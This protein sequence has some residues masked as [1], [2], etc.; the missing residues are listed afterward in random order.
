[1]PDEKPEL[2]TT[3]EQ[4]HRVGAYDLARRWVDDPAHSLAHR[5]R[6]DPAVQ[7]DELATMA[8]LADW[9]TRWLPTAIHRALLAGATVAQVAKAINMRPQQVTWTWECWSNRQLEHGLGKPDE[10]ARVAHL[11]ID[12]ALGGDR[13][14][15]EHISKRAKCA[16][17]GGGGEY[18]DGI[19]DPYWRHD[20]S[21]IT[22]TIAHP[23]VSRDEEQA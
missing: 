16:R 22:T 8:A 6:Y 11:L 2:F 23:F 3:F 5:Y 1:M 12:D 20:D 14:T 4:A 9:L 10:H 7:I 13:E 17:C 19:K 18:V 15:T 21:P